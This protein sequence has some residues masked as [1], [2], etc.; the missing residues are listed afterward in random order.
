MAMQVESQQDAPVSSLVGGIV[1]DAQKLLVEQ[2]TLFQVE[3]K[4]DLQRTW[5]ALIPLVIGLAVMLTALF[6]LGMGAS[7]YLCTAMPA[8]PLWGGYVAVGVIVAIAGILLS[9]WGKSMLTAVKPVDTALKGLE[10][11]V[12]WKTKN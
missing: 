1:Q 4:H 6:L 8:L 12:T 10:E 7:H 2:M 9:L 5:L 3:L 11:N